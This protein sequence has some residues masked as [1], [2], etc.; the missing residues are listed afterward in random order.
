MKHILFK[1]GQSSNDFSHQGE[2]RVRLLPTKNIPVPTPA[3]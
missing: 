1:G 2:V 3:F